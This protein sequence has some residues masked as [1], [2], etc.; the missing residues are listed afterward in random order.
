MFDE[1]HKRHAPPCSGVERPAEHWRLWSVVHFP[2]AAGYERLGTKE[3]CEARPGLNAAI[4]MRLVFTYSNE[5]D[6]ADRKRIAKVKKIL[7]VGR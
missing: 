2:G 7:G 6:P 4:A 1:R 5:I 3:Q